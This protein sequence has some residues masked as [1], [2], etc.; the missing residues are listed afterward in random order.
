M[1]I[2]ETD[3]LLP[4]QKST[5]NRLM[6]INGNDKHIIPK[7]IWL[8]FTWFVDRVVDG[9]FPGGFERWGDLLD[10]VYKQY[11]ISINKGGN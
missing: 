3:D 6:K 5:I 7:N 11:E 1:K 8:T 9:I 10:Y 2:I 4:W